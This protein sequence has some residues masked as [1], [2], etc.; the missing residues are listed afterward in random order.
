MSLPGIDGIRLLGSP[1]GRPIAT[2]PA[3]READGVQVQIMLVL[4]ELDAAAIRR[5][6][7]ECS[8]LEAMLVDIDP[9]VILPLLDHGIDALGRPYLLAAWPGAEVTEELAVQGRLPVTMVAAAAKAAAD[10]LEALAAKGMVGPPPA[11]VVHESRLVTMGPPLPPGL[12][13]LEAAQGD[14][15]GHEPPEVLGGSDWTPA[16]QVYACASLFWTLLSGQSPFT[17]GRAGTSALARLVSRDPPPMR[18]SDVPEQVVAILRRALSMDP[19]SRHATPAELATAL[20]DAV[21]RPLGSLYLLD[22][23]IGQGACG[24]VWAGRRRSGGAPIAAKVLRPQLVREGTEL[25]RFVREYHILSRLPHPHLVRVDDFFAQGGEYA[26]VMDLIRGGN[27][28]QF[29]AR[30]KLSTAE[31]ASL[32]AQIAGGLAAVHGAGV[33]HRDVKP[34]NVL[35]A[36]R[37][38][39]P[40]ALLS[41]FGIARPLEDSEHTQVI[42]TPAYLAP[43]LAAD[44]APS[45]ASDVYALG[46]TAY[47]LLADRKPF[48][49]KDIDALLLAHLD[50]HAA[51]PAGLPDEVWDLIAACL[52]KDP[53]RRPSAAQVA[54]RLARFAS[55]GPLDA[56]AET[57]YRLEDESATILSAHPAPSRPE[58]PARRRRWRR[59]LV[60]AIVVVAGLT[61]GILFAAKEKSPPPAGEPSRSQYPVLATVTV[62]GTAATVS[63]RPDAG[64]L[65]G[66]QGYLVFDVN[67][68]QMRQLTATM[69][70][71]NVTDFTVEGLRAG[72]KACFYVIAVGVTVSPPAQLPPPPCIT[73]PTA[74][75]SS[76]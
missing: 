35:V 71:A 46:V 73:A 50:Q 11:L 23:Q 67:G 37:D 33:V 15:T 66:F 34:E 24:E 63:W 64:T 30:R 65:P 45:P 59:I 32:L 22:S 72:R 1:S 25:G 16:G 49:G 68:D 74:K 54:A 17:P 9:E 52:A 31:S 56:G 44:R 75:P 19:A 14:G 21:A 39:Q 28:R 5:V 27:L 8:H 4:A 20:R 69:L 18:R 43:E 42:G 6:R 51:R 76:T 40:V 29:A 60:A 7:A 58:R 26:I 41:D 57:T 12:A 38:G 70:G 55:S 53:A 13:E 47:E 10:G 36:Q 2:A 3:V 62:D 48:Y 61:A